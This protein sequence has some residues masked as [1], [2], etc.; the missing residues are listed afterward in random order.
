MTWAKL[1]DG[2][3]WNHKVVQA[4]NEAAGVYARALAH[5]SSQLT[6]GFVPEKV[7]G[8][9]ADGRRKP[10]TA[11]LEAGLWERDDGGYRIADYLDYN[12]S[13]AVVEARREALAE[14][15][16][17]GGLAAG[18]SRGGKAKAKATASR[19]VQANASADGEQSVEPPSRPVPLD[20]SSNEEVVDLSKSTTQEREVFKHWVREYKRDSKRTK[21]NAK[22][23]QK[24]RARLREGYSVED[25]CVAIRGAK[26]DDWLMGRDPQSPGY[27]DLVTL[28]RDG[29]QVERL[30]ALYKPPKKPKPKR[31][32][33]EWIEHWIAKGLSREEAELHVANQLGVAA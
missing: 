23:R 6:D 22:R 4:G 14:A 8:L 2:F 12:P 16:R 20:T 15:G 17:R 18:A 28:L 26:Q 10:I 13:R 21:L 3:C 11:L 29:A 24:I 27:D 5:C 19:S 1:D 30:I 33:A 32:R 9:I 7:A 31:S 25:L